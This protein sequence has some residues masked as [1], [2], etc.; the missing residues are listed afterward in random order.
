MKKETFWNFIAQNYDDEMGEQTLAITRR[1]IAKTDKVLD[2]GCA[3]GAYTVSLAENVREIHGIDISPKM[4]EFA[5]AKSQDIKFDVASI[6]DVDETY[7][8]VL[9]FSIL[10]LVDD[11]E[12]VIAKI[13]E[14]LKPGGRFISVTACM[15]GQAG[16][17]I[18]GFFTRL[19]RIVSLNMFTVEELEELIARRF[20]IVEIE[21]FSSHVVLV[22]AEK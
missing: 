6:F 3:R 19:F 18:A 21:R 2:Y 9:A 14:L 4:I 13:D 20:K 15:K 17:R 11:I 22:V 12:K 5:K 16:M 10:H 8:V 1:H 7:D